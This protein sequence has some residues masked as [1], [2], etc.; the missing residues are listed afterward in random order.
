MVYQIHF[1]IHYRD[2]MSNLLIL[3]WYRD[4]PVSRA[5]LRQLVFLRAKCDWGKPALLYKL[6]MVLFLL[7]NLKYGNELPLF[8]DCSIVFYC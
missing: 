2:K 5:D 1:D 3:L 8:F 7:Y 4:I 6:A